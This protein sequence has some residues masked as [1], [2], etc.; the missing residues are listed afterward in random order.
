MTSK[1]QTKKGVNIVFLNKP[2]FI[3]LHS[4]I[5]AIIEYLNV[6]CVNVEHLFLSCMALSQILCLFVVIV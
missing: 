5:K 6:A 4:E 3:L 1:E 2:G